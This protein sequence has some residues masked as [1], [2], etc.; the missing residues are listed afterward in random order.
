MCH[1]FRNFDVRHFTSSFQLFASVSSQKNSRGR[2]G[3]DGRDGMFLARAA[4]RP[5]SAAAQTAARCCGPPS[6]SS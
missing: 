5:P 4:V 2:D 1:A 6:G 3:R